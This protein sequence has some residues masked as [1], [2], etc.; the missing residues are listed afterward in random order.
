MK[1][2]LIYNLQNLFLCFFVIFYLFI[3]HDLTSN[4]ADEY[5]KINLFHIERNKN[6]NQV[7]YAIKLTKDCHLPDK[8]SMFVYWLDLELKKYQTS[9]IKWF[10]QRAYGIKQQTEKF[11]S[12]LEVILYAL[13]ERKIYVKYFQEQKTKECKAIATMKISNT[14]VEL[15]KVYVF[16][17]ER[18]F[19]PTVKYIELFGETS[20]REVIK[21]KISP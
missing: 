19:I 15:R 16:A 7:H 12:Q 18:F 4:Q 9:N 3:S 11:P 17:K 14:K 6:R 13:P 21:E 5:L 1:N 2:R 20:E 8:E 10:E